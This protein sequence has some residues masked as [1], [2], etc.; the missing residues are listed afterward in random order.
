MGCGGALA[1]GDG[2]LLRLTGFPRLCGGRPL[3]GQ[4]L[5]CPGARNRLCF[6]RSALSAKQSARFRRRLPISSLPPR[7]TNTALVRW[8]PQVS[9][10]HSPPMTWLSHAACALFLSSALSAVLARPLNPQVGT[11]TTH[12]GQVPARALRSLFASDTCSRAPGLIQVPSFP[13]TLHRTPP[14]V[15]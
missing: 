6:S 1:F 11:A 10:L 2:H 15:L 8:D 14:S 9:P 5:W 4:G 13:P 3:A 12:T 7:G